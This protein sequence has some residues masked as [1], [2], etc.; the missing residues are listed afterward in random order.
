MKGYVDSFFGASRTTEIESEVSYRR[1]WEI[2]GVKE[3]VWLKS[4]NL[5]KRLDTIKKA[6]V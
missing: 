6:R 2:Q 1:D 5:N 4:F 3:K